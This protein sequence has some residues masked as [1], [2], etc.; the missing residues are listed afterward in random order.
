METKRIAAITMARNDDFYLRKWVS[1][2]GAQLGREN[3]YIYLDGLDQMVGD[4]CEGTHA[5]AVEKI[6]S[7]VVEAE[8]GRLKFLSSKAAELLSGGYDL[9]IGVDADEFIVV[10]PRLGKTLPEYLSSVRV[11]GSLSALGL[12]FGQKMGEEADIT[13]D[14]PFLQ[15]R[16]YAQ[17]GTRYTKPSI[18][19]EPLTWGS[20]FHRI[21]GHNFHIAKDLYLFHFGY[22]DMKRLQDRF[23]DKDRLAQG[24]EKHMH[25]RSRAIRLVTDLP[26]RDFGRWTSLARI[27]Q[28]LVRPPY[29]WNKP[30]MFGLRIIVR[31]PERFQSII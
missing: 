16:H 20:G 12:D 27:C 21:K 30:A 7:H 2:Y 4:Y 31:I 10:D 8:K 9:V 29:A 11:K 1:Y 26:A 18:L 5:Q 15:Q 24:W 13:E 25:K 6:G 23:Q 22:F 17:I 28:T 3:L 14:R 19:A